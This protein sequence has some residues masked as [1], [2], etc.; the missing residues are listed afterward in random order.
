MSFTDE[1]TE[2]KW[3]K[4]LKC[5]WNTISTKIKTTEYNCCLQHSLCTTTQKMKSWIWHHSEWIMNMI[6]KYDEI[7]KIM[8]HRVKSDFEYY[9]DKE[10]ALRS[11]EKIW[12]TDRKEKKEK[13]F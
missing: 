9:W 1:W 5:I 7:H 12:Q 6:Q 10:T 11:N 13:S 3:I 4:Q 2:W 8:N